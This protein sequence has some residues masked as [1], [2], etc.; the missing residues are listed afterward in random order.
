MR[1]DFLESTFCKDVL[2]KNEVDGNDDGWLLLPLES[3]EP[4]ARLV[5]TH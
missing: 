4:K 2:V 5:L 1:M 3:L